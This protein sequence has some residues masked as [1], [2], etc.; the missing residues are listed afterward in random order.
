M[1]NIMD[2]VKL[3]NKPSRN[4]FDLSYKNNFSAKVGELLPVMCKAV[5][6]GDSFNID[7]SSFTRLQPLNTAAFARMREYYDFYFVPMTSLWNKFPSVITQMKSNLTRASGLNLSDNV[8]VSSELP[9]VTCE[10]IAKFLQVFSRNLTMRGN[11]FGYNRALL[12]AKLLDYLGYGDFSPYVYI[13]EDHPGVTWET[14]PMPYNLPLSIL[15]LLAYQHVYADFFRDSQWEKTNPA[16]FNCDYITGNGD[17]QI[18]LSDVITFGDFEENLNF[19]DLRYSSFNKDLFLG[20]QPNAQYGSEASVSVNGIGAG[21]GF[22][23]LSYPGPTIGGP[24]TPG[25]V[26]WENTTYGNTSIL[27]DQDG[28]QAAM[29]YYD[30]RVSPASISGQE[31]ARFSILALRQAEQMQKWKEISQSVSED[32]KKQIEAHWGISVSDYLSDSSRYLGGI[33]ASL[34]INPVV[35]QNIT[36]SYGADMAGLGTVVN[37]GSIHFESRGEYGFIIGVYHATPIFDYMCGNLDPVVTLTDATDFP[38]P[39]LDSIGMEQVPSYLLSNLPATTDSNKAANKFVKDNPF[40][41][42]APRYVTWKTSVDVAHGAF[43]TTLKNW[44]LPFT[45]D[46]LN[47]PTSLA[48]TDIQNPNAVSASRNSLTWT[49]KKVNPSVMNP[50]FAVAADSSVDSDQLLCSSFMDVKVVRNLDVDGLPY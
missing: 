3:R 19:F 47:L 16:T 20:L 4:G 7:L 10:Q 13:D 6:P 25:P 2:V 28:N 32:Y 49:F 50:L 40:L 5:L 41:G 31:I 11:I 9:Y 15:P 43:A 44:V 45:A 26:S 14:S 12:A 36:G 34:D 35:N 24:L 46:N 22:S 17:L 27:V 33:G 39:E 23:K 21:V 37:K 29:G 30:N 48:D 42:Y 38:I 8:P 1:P 18:P